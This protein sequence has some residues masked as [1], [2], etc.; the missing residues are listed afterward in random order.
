[1]NVRLLLFVVV[2]VMLVH[3]KCRA[4]DSLFGENS[5]ST[6]WG[7][8]LVGQDTSGGTRAR[9]RDFIGVGIGMEL[10]NRA[11]RDAWVAQISYAHHISAAF[12]YALD[13]G[14]LRTPG[15]SSAT[16]PK[17]NV[18]I[19]GGFRLSSPEVLRVVF[20]LQAGIGVMS[21]A[22]IPLHLYIEPGVRI[23]VSSKIRLQFSVRETQYDP[24]IA[25]IGVFA[26]V[27]VF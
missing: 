23:G 2:Y 18:F 13:L 22:L 15:S 25:P 3:P 7:C 4:E 9:E 19:T 8:Q 16:T 21:Q 12:G 11:F 26:L 14:I 10:R 1:M 24:D 5:S 20:F 6:L 17:A 27:L